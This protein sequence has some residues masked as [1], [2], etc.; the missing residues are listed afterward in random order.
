MC[1]KERNP[2][3]ELLVRST[4]DHVVAVDLGLGRDQFTLVAFYFPPSIDQST[5]VRELAGVFDSL[6]SR[7]ILLAGDANVRSPLWGPTIPDHRHHD[8]GGPFV[9]FIFVRTLHVWNDPA[10][11]PTFETERAQGWIDVTLSSPSLFHRRSHWTVHRTSMSDHNFITFSLVGSHAEDAL[12]SPPRFTKRRLLRFA[13]AAE[14]YFKD[15]AHLLH[16][17]EAVGGLDYWLG[18]LSSGGF[19]ILWHWAALPT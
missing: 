16:F 17:K 3:I 18:E 1:P 7:S 2:G 13:R 10:S 14:A 19:C 9:E 11:L 12:P 5:L 8:D 4:T 15:N 6:Q